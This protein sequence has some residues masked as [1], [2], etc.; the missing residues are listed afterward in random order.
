MHVTKT[1]HLGK[2]VGVPASITRID[3]HL[4]SS[5][6][7]NARRKISPMRNRAQ[8]FMEKH[9]FWGLPAASP[10]ALDFKVMALNADIKIVPLALCASSFDRL[11]KFF[12]RASLRVI[13]QV[14]HR[15]RP[16]SNLQDIVSYIDTLQEDGCA[17]LVA[18]TKIQRR[19][20]SAECAVQSCSPRPP[21]LLLHRA[22][23][24][25]PSPSLRHRLRPPRPD[26]PRLLRPQRP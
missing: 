13:F 26:R 16:A 22:D 20:A 1:A 2:K 23:L 3:R 14:P 11:H 9:K 6:I 24:L 15:L 4:K 12:L 18:V 17:A 7:G 25:R 5:G 21:R 10:N 19:T 8:P